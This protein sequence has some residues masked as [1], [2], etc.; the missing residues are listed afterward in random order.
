MLTLKK[1]NKALAQL[2]DIKLIKGEGYYY[3]IGDDVSMGAEGVCV[4]TLNCLEIEGWIN[5]A[6]ER[7]I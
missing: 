7:L 2:G 3:F 1:V 6:K 4:N 5:E